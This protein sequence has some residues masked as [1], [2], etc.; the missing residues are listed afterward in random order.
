MKKSLSIFGI[1]GSVGNSTV[2]LL[3]KKKHEFELIAITCNSDIENISLL[4]NEFN[5]KIVAIAN[6]KKLDELKEN[7]PSDIKC[8]SGVEGICEAAS[9]EADIVIASIVGLAGLKPLIESIKSSS[10]IALANKE[11]VVS[12][13]PLI[14]KLSKENNC[15][16]IPIDSEHNAIFQI[17]DGKSISDVSKIYLTA[18]GGPFYNF[19]KEDLTDITPKQAT[20]HPIWKM[21]KKISVDS[22][23]L[24]NKGL[25]IIEAHYLFEIPSEGIEVIIHRQ[26]II[27]GLVLMKNGSLFGH[28]GKPSMLKPIDHALSWPKFI[29][30]EIDPISISDLNNLSLEIIDE[31]KYKSLLLSRLALE[32]GGIYPISLNAANEIAVNAFLN[33]QIQFLDIIKIVHKVIEGIGH[34]DNKSLETVSDLDGIFSVDNEARRK[35]L[36]SIELGF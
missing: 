17:L 23:T 31:K 10:I 3:R 18:S 21:G 13:G 11:C 20:N 30:N 4:A 25:E 33:H 22:A 36:E 1:T 34:C 24:M 26:S 35:A 16:I 28:F 14:K 12:A 29:Q 7:I 5:P 8:L 6:E 15:K 19:S 32:K 2:E 9:Y 27:H